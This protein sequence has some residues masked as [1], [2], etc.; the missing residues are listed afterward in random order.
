MFTERDPIGK[1]LCWASYR[2]IHQYAVNYADGD[3]D[4]SFD[5]NV[6]IDN[7]F[8]DIQASMQVLTSL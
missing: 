4:D 6:A 7:D 5:K 1:C 2:R 8:Y 3:K